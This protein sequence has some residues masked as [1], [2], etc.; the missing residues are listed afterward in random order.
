MAAAGSPTAA[1]NA[2]TRI[3]PISSDDVARAELGPK[4]EALVRG[5]KSHFA[6]ASQA[7]HVG[8][9]GLPPVD[10]FAIASM[11]Q[12]YA[13]EARENFGEWQKYLHFSEV[14][15]TRNLIYSCDDFELLVLCW[16]PGHA[17]RIH[18]HDKSHCWLSV[19]SGLV[20]EQ[21]Y[22]PAY[23]QSDATLVLR[24]EAENTVATGGQATNDCPL[25][26]LL[27]EAIRRE[28]DVGYI[29]DT[30]SLHRVANCAISSRD[31]TPEDQPQLTP[32]SVTLHLYAPPIRRVRLYEP[33]EHKVY[34]RTPGYFSIHGK[35]N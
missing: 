24:S 19:L 26:L 27:K 7:P 17:S 13:G 35:K 12:K 33:G 6:A 3:E 29:N 21:L 20:S 1:T 18:N 34:N 23:I 5:L 11:L 31:A 14:H 30:L 16:G 22:Q 2:I 10:N 25:L 9:L 28:G 15:Y 8:P 4:T 32:G